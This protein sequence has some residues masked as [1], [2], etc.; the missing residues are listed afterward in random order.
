MMN[1]KIKK[2]RTNKLL[3]I[4]IMYIK[5]SDKTDKNVLSLMEGFDGH[6]S[7]MIAIVKDLVP[8]KHNKTCYSS[9]KFK[10]KDIIRTI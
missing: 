3:Q 5:R 4:I 1:I 10:R 7:R 8:L 2:I 9:D 6:I